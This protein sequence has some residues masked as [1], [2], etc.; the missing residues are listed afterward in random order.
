MKK[1]VIFNVGGALSAYGDFDSQRFVIDL[2]KKEDFS[3]VLD[4]LKPLFDKERLSKSTATIGKGKYHI[5]QLF[6]SHLDKDHTADY[7]KFSEYFFPQFMTCPNDN[8]KQ[9][10]IFKINRNKIGE[11]T[12]L[13][14][15]ILSD[16]K[17]RYPLH[18]DRPIQSKINNIELNYIR[19][20]NCED[21]KDLEVAYANNISLTLFVS[22]N[23]KTALFPGDLLKEG[24]KHLINNN[25]NFKKLL[26]NNGIDYLI[27]PHHGLQTSFSTV[28]FE[29]IKG[30]KTRLN[31]ISEKVRSV[32]SNENRSDVD[33]RYR[34]ED[35]CTGEN[36]LGK[37]GVKTSLGHIVIDFETSEVEV[38]QYTEINEVIEEF[39]TK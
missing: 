30:N 35:Y 1:I 4:F 27:A 5:D 8:S 32:E 39:C 15:K 31:I 33:S 26:S 36:F 22:Y 23:N 12:D 18:E 25:R 37:Y 34:S 13:K 28:F 20:L 38:K 17:V 24:M 16:M 11:L 19:P 14:K 2:G 3:P 9:R 7:E 21:G 6:L 29:T 10:N